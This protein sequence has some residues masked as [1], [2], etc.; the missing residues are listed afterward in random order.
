M[1][2]NDQAP[3]L[4]RYGIR[5]DEMTKPCVVLFDWSGDEATVV[6]NPQLEQLE[7]IP[8]EDVHA[9]WEADPDDNAAPSWRGIGRRPGT[10]AIAVV[11]G[12]CGGIGFAALFSPAAAQAGAHGAPDASSPLLRGAP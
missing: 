10:V 6:A 5:D 8:D 7:L 11:L 9:G 3:V 12:I 1:T 4:A 2:M